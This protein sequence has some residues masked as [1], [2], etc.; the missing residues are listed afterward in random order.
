MVLLSPTIGG[1][2]KLVNVCE[3]YAAKHGL[4]YK[5][6]KSELMIF[7][8]GT[9]SP[10][11]VPPVTLNGI[12]MNVVTSFKYLGHMVTEHLRDD[13]D[14]DRERRALSI[15]GNMIAHR[16]K[17]CAAS[18]KITLFRAHCTSFYTCN[19]WAR[20]TQRSLSALRVQYNNAFRALLGLPRWCSASGMF[21]D[22][23]VDGFHAVLRKW[24]AAAL[25][26]LCAS[27]NTILAVIADRLDS[28]YV[29]HW[30]R[31]HAIK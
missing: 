31:A 5:V 17:R 19:L 9:K 23:H 22:A 18:V 20:Y 10:E 27:T 6:S 24:Y 2:R 1:L 29:Q 16:F 25:C 14:M 21:A 4:K 13:E 12:P 28:C 11:Q 8:A 7:K 30:V 26:R 15:R 3:R